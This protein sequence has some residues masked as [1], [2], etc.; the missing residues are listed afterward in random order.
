MSQYAIMRKETTGEAWG[1]VW[2][3]TEWLLVTGSVTQ[4]VGRSW[5]EAGV[6]SGLAQEGGDSGQA[7]SWYI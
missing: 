7:L 4:N 2:D 6:M 5:A 1:A 3:G